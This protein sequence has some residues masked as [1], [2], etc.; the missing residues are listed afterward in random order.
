[1]SRFVGTLAA[2]AA[3][4]A[5]PIG[6]T[7]LTARQQPPAQ[8]GGRGI[9]SNLEHPVLPIG[10][11]LPDF[12]LPG[13]DGRVVGCKVP[14]SG[15][16]SS[17]TP[18]HVKLPRRASVCMAAGRRVPPVSCCRLHQNQHALRSATRA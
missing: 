2:A 11:P 6:T 12:S 17:R 1:M 9:Q 8:G 3:L 15:S 7:P 4:A 13:V 18:D 16:G 5:L 14:P 10:S